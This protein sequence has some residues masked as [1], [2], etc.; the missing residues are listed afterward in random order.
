MKTLR[1]QQKAIRELV[2]KTIDLLRLP[3]YRLKLVFKAPTGAGKTVM[4]SQML[5]NLTEELQA[6]GDIPCRQAAYMWIAPNRLHLQSYAKLKAFFSE[7]RLLRPVIYDELDRSE[8]IIGQGEI[9]FVNW[10]SINKEKNILVRESEQNISLYDIT[11]RTQEEYGIPIVMIIDEEH[12]FWSERADKSAKVLQRINPKVEIRISATPKTMS[13][14]IVHIRYQE[15]INEEMIKKQVVMNL[16]LA[17]DYHDERELNIHLLQCALKKREQLAEAYR[18]EGVNINPLLL[19]QLPNDDQKSMT[20]EDMAIAKQVREHLRIAEDISVENHRLAIWLSGESKN[21]EKLEEADNMTEVLLFK[22]AIALG[23]D[24]P[25]A[26]V[27]LIFRRL[28]SNEFTVQTVGRIMRMPEQKFYQNDILNNGYVYTDISKDQINIVSEENYLRKDVVLA[29]RRKELDNVS[30]PSYYRVYKSSDR[31]RLGPD[32]RQELIDSFVCNWTLVHPSSPPPGETVT[33]I[34]RRRMEGRICL[35][36]RRLSVKIPVDVT[37]QNE[38]G[39]VIQADKRQAFARSK[40]EV[41]RIYIGYCRSL[42]GHFEKSHSTDILAGYLLAAMEDFFDLYGTEAK[43]VILNENNR[44][45]FTDVIVRALESYEKK[46]LERK[47][48]AKQRDMETYMW[49]VPKERLYKA[50]THQSRPEMINHALLPFMERT[51]ASTP[52]Q[53]FTAFLEKHK[54]YIDWWYKNGD[55]GRQHY[56]IPYEVNGEKLLFYVDFIVKMKN[57]QLFLFDTKDKDSDSTAPQKHNALLEYMHNSEHQELQLKG[58]ILIE[59]NGLWR[60]SSSRIENTTNFADWET[61]FP[62]HYHE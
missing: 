52:E 18:Q 51:D 40:G 21:L 48:S 15:V 62:E 9:L 19:I 38:V 14:D 6:R 25:R 13:D 57:G 5:A 1:F 44:D 59:T 28:T 12:Q 53:R 35:D 7:T 50:S 27:L 47:K 20:A 39:T 30:L 16:D 17:E 23:W 49:E 60:Y 34:N 58:G 32:F 22:Q 11:R 31:N 43:R 37:F 29:F 8:G 56:S 24:C 33:A 3:D 46:L 42:L 26:A 45:K 36:E 55:E 41:H 10:E 2:D 4:A 61:F 54:P